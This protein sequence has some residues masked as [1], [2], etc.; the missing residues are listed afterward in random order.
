MTTI[1]AQR[2]RFAIIFV[3][4][5]NVCRSPFAERVARWLIDNRLSLQDANRVITRSAGTHALH[6]AAMDRQSEMHLRALGLD[7]AGFVATQFAADTVSNA[8][9]VLTA[10]LRH[11]AIVVEH[12]PP[13]LKTTFTLREF[14]YL[15]EN[16]DFNAHQLPADPILRA[17][18]IRE[19]VR[20]SRGLNPPLAGQDYE[21]PDP[22]GKDDSSHAQAARIIQEAISGVIDRL[23]PLDDRVARIG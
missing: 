7:A 9:L 17:R 8:D 22:Y 14:A 21:V 13:A 4:T 12:H 20:D 1:G 3:C 15:L 5:G 16:L 2:E 6:G 19:F 18:T 10:T 11:R 23:W